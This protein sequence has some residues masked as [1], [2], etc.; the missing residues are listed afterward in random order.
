MCVTHWLRYWD[1]CQDWGLGNPKFCFLSDRQ[2]Y[3]A[4]QK[5]KKK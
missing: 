5:K 1:V 4:A 2:M 3:G